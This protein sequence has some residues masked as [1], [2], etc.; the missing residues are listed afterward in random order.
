VDFAYEAMDAGE[1]V[2]G[3]EGF[4]A[5][6]GVEAGIL[7]FGFGEAGDD[8]DGHVW[9]ELADAGDELGAVHAGHDVVCEDE[10]NGGGKL[11]IAEL[12]EGA[13][14]AK[15]GDDEVAGSL[16]D[17]LAGSGLDSVVINEQN[18]SG[19]AFL[20]RGRYGSWKKKPTDVPAA[21]L[22]R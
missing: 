3:K 6:V 18:R 13:L 14:G 8:E 12:F 22:F 5:E 11:A 10:I 19:H 15:N 17:G 7:V 4:E 1:E 16:E 9:G 21:G 2:V 20:K